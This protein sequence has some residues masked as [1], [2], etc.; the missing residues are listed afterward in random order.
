MR[1][2]ILKTPLGFF[3]IAYSDRGITGTA[4]PRK[5]KEEVMLDL[6]SRFG[7]EMLVQSSFPERYKNL[8]M[9]YFSGVKVDFSQVEIDLRGTEFQRDVWE[10][11]QHIPFGEVRSYSWIARRLQNPGAKRAVGN[12]L[13]KNPVPPIVPCHRVI[14]AKDIGGFSSGIAMKRKLLKNETSWW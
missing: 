4:L 3:G 11:C 2:S 13:G 1:Y 14:G 8:F 7:S 10:T 6:S 5:D 9:D 12:A